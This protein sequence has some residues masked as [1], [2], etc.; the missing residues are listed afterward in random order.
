MDLAGTQEKIASGLFAAIKNF[1][2]KE[3]QMEKRPSG[4][5]QLT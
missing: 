5:C 3:L 2:K 4:R 1:Q